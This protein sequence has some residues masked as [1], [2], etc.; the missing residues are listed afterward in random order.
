MKLRILTVVAAT[1]VA[2]GAPAEAKGVSRLTITGVGLERTIVVGGDG[3]LAL[4][5]ILGAS[6]F[7]VAMDGGGAGADHVALRSAADPQESDLGPRLRLTWSVEWY[8]TQYVVQDLYLYADGGPVLYTPAGQ[9]LFD[10]T[11]TGAWHRGSPRLVDVIQAVGVPSPALL[12]AAA[13]AASAP[14][15]V[16]ASTILRW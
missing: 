8:H 4:S 5:R 13:A 3:S 9:A 10:Q 1:L 14:L 6:E 11:T 15:R 7:F 2:F 16:G 12:R